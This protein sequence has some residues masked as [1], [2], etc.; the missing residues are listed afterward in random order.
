MK[1]VLILLTFIPFCALSQ[2][3]GIVIDKDSKDP[4]IGAK[5]IASTGE[6]VLSNGDG[7]FSIHPNSYPTTPCDIRYLHNHFRSFL[8]Y[9][10]VSKNLQYYLKQKQ[11][12]RTVRFE[13]S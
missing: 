3:K 8:K 5:I 2:V 11:Y 6:K 7:R 13:Q 9:S 12:C 10:N 4:V 1:N